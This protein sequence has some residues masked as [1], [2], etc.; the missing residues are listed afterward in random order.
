MFMSFNIRYIIASTKHH[1]NEIVESIVR[2]NNPTL[3]KLHFW[4]NIDQFA[5][6]CHALL[7][8]DYDCRDILHIA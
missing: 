2:W 3:E 5:Q 4:H 1:K 7:S 6:N 8:I